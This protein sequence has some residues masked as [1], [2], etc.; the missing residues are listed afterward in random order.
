[1]VDCFV[2]KLKI[3]TDKRA[4]LPAIVYLL[5]D[6]LR[7]ASF[8]G[9]PPN[10]MVYIKCMDLGC[11]DVNISSAL[12][13]SR[14]DEFVRTLRPVPAVGIRSE[15]TDEIAVWFA[16]ELEPCRA[17]AARLA[18]GRSPNGWFWPVAV[19]GWSR[20]QPLAQ[21]LQAIVFQAARNPAGIAGL[22]GVLEPLLRGDI[23]LDLLDSFEERHVFRLTASLGLTTRQNQE[24]A[25]TG[26]AEPWLPAEPFSRPPA[27]GGLAEQDRRLVAKAFHRW[28]PDASRA[29]LLT[30]L[31]LAA[32]DREA[33]PKE[34]RHTLLAVASMENIRIHGTETAAPRPP[35]GTTAPLPPA[36][37]TPAPVR[38]EI[39]GKRTTRSTA[40]AWTPVRGDSGAAK[41]PFGEIPVAAGRSCQPQRRGHAQVS[42]P[43]DAAAGSTDSGITAV[44][45]AITEKPPTPSPGDIQAQRP[46]VRPASTEK[47]RSKASPARL[48]ETMVLRHPFAGTYSR[49]AGFPLLITVVEELAIDVIFT[50]HTDFPHAALR[51]AV[52]R[53][54]AGWQQIPEDDPVVQFLSKPE[55]IAARAVRTYRPVS[56]RYLLDNA[57]ATRRALFRIPRLRNPDEL[58]D[59]DRA[60][61]VF[62]LA[63]RRYVRH[64][65]GLS[66]RTLVRRPAFIA[67]T[68]THMD[69]TAELKT[70]DI[71][72]RLAGLDVNPGWVPWLGK[73]VQIHYTEEKI[74]GSNNPY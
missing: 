11:F 24:N 17:L 20:R 13:S 3:R 6:A 35:T 23:I 71:R 43:M 60:A 10:G 34:I 62:V 63:A 68:R 57:A 33:G 73:V 45:S 74:N 21:N 27:P 70:V 30:G 29:V 51:Q 61:D 59:F 69:I 8:P 72:I 28:G 49:F 36:A 44:P 9:I 25:S 53:H 67:L 47:I 15:H 52:L 18:E 4:C 7:T 50:G 55:D 58:L 38:E 46:P 14:I 2:R 48:P 37:N 64:F 41:P 56:R 16:D 54:I 1:M 5:E 39:Q 12:L 42:R 65:A 40:T 19:K 32:R 22:A 31:V 66:I 26:P